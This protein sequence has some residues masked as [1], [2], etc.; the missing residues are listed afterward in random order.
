MMAGAVTLTLRNTDGQESSLDDGL[1]ITSLA[2]QFEETTLFAALPDT[3][4]SAALL[5]DF[6]LDGDID[7]VASGLGASGWMAINDGAGSFSAS[8][9][10]ARLG[11]WPTSTRALVAADFDSD[12]SADIYAGNAGDSNAT[13]ADRLFQNDGN[14]YF[15]DVSQSALPPGQL[16]DTSCLAAG[17]LNGDGR[18]DLVVGSDTPGAVALRIYLNRSD[19]DG[20]LLELAPEAFTPEE[21]W[22]VSSLA[23]VDIDG[24]GD[25][26]LLVATT[27]TEDGALGRPD[28]LRLL[29]NDGTGQLLAA[30]ALPTIEASVAHI[31]TGDVDDDG[32][33]DVV[34]I[35]HGGQDHLLINDGTGTF[36]D[37]TFSNMPFDFADGSWGVLVDV[38]R[39][40]DRDLLIA[41]AGGQS[42]IYLNDGHGYFA[43][44]TSALP[45]HPSDASVVIAAADVDA[46]EDQDLL[47]FNA[48]GGPSRLYLSAEKQPDEAH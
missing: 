15:S 11:N 6:D 5:N 26:D 21:S 34:T 23:L 19:A 32:D 41:T 37:L 22:L 39:D 45:A 40:A 2:L 29:L 27:S 43:D 9:S 42:R 13:K 30:D 48:L 44:H 33:E 31:C 8:D 17:D 46:D 25:L 24:D 10:S 35:T 14:G 12:G 28:G 7:V 18:P 36:D 4:L 16:D 38:D 3:N 47:L 1:L 20:I